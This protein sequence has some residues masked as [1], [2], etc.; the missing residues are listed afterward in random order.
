MS[1]LG[2]T[3]DPGPPSHLPDLLQLVV[4][5]EEEGQVHEGHVHVA[6]APELPV[7]LDGVPPSREGM[8]VDLHQQDTRTLAGAGCP[9]GAQPLGEAVLPLEDRTAPPACCCLPHHASPP[10]K[11]AQGDEL[12]P[13]TARSGRRAGRDHPTLHVLEQTT[14]THKPTNASQDSLRRVLKKS[15]LWAR[16]KARVS[17]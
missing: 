11:M 8:L 9:A 5:L 17:G 14:E 15:G 4:I 12:E 2:L 3:R 1:E 7:L 6:V 16:R 13:P 10:R